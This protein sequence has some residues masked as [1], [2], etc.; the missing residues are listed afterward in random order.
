MLQ[1]FF[2][3][4]LASSGKVFYL[5]HTI[6]VL[7]AIIMSFSI[8]FFKSIDFNSYNICKLY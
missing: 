4:F 6:T 3:N 2:L 5:T 1:Y 7:L 8:Q